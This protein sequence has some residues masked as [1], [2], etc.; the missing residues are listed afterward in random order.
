[1]K[2]YIG[3]FAIVLFT[4]SYSME[5]HSKTDRTQLA[6]CLTEKGWV[7][8]EAAG[9]EACR[10]QRRSFGDAFANIKTVK[11]GNSA[12]TSEKKKCTSQDIHYTPTWLLI[13]NGIVI[14]RLE[15][16]QSLNELANVSGCE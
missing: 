7:M 15:G 12:S 6:K 14:K 1:M 16:N 11:C 13:K 9:C 3:I 2:Q 5:S 4:A 10:N 8:Y